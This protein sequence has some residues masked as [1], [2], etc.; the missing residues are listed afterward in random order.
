MNHP[1]IK[2]LES[3]EVKLDELKKI[4]EHS[5]KSALSKEIINNEEFL[6]IFSITPHTALNWREK[7]MI[8]YSQINSKIYYRV[9]D[10]KGLIEENY[11]QV[12]KKH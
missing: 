12:K 10:V 7:G 3:L 11:K 4:V 6:K 2:S 5:N 1:F 9:D 8:S